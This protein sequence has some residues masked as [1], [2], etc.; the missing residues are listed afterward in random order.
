MPGKIALG[1]ELNLKIP[2]E[3]KKR[4]NHYLS[5][6]PT[7]DICSQGETEKKAIENLQEAVSLFI[8]SC[9]ERETLDV[10]L[11]NCGLSVKKYKT[12]KSTHIPKNVNTIDVPIPFSIPA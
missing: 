10:V 2:Y 4:K 12:Y 6:C 5:T 11:K 9:I 3:L 8:I 1:A 7:I